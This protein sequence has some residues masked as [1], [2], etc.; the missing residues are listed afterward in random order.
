MVSCSCFTGG[1]RRVNLD[2]NPVI[3]HEWF[4]VGFV[5]LDNVVIA[6]FSFTSFAYH[7]GVFKSLCSG[8]C[9]A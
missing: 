3:S 4:L 6:L 5:L 9:V 1:T 7:F 2:T 8:V